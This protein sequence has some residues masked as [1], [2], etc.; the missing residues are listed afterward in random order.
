MEGIMKIYKIWQNVNNDFDT[1]DSAIVCAENEEEAKKICPNKYYQF[2]DGIC[3]WKPL[4]NPEQE[5]KNDICSSWAT[6]IK[7]VMVEYIGETKQGLRKGVICASF[8]AG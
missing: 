3:I 6:N 8:N 5:N 4:D 2:V 1:Y 7:D